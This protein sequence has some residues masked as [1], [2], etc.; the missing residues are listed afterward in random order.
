MLAKVH[1]NVERNGI[2][3]DVRGRRLKGGGEKTG[4][5][6]LEQGSTPIGILVVRCPLGSWDI[7]PKRSESL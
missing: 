4:P 2:A 6:S 3:W 1:A 7:S 5:M